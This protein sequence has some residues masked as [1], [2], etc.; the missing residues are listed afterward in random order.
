MAQGERLTRQELSWLLSQ[1]A[2]RAAQTL[3]KGVA[4]LTLEPPSA[5]SAQLE[6]SLSA[7]DDAMKMLASLQSSSV[8]RGI[9]G[10]I[11]L[12]ALVCEVTPEA[13]V[14]IAPGSG[15]EVHGDEAEL[16]RMIQVLLAQ[17]TGLEA[18][19]GAPEVWINREGD[20]V[21]VSVALGPDIVTGMTSERAWL[22]RMATRYGGRLT[23]EGGQ[24]SLLLPA[25][26]AVER[27]EME[28]LRKELDAA[29][30]QGEAYARELAAV[31]AAAEGSDQPPAATSTMPPPASSLSAVLA[32]SA[33]IA[34]Q[35]KTISASLS[36]D[37][38]VVMQRSTDASRSADAVRSANVQLQELAGELGRLSRVPLDE[39]PTRADLASMAR[40]VLEDADARA[41]RHQISLHSRVPDK[42]H[43]LVP[44]EAMQAMMRL[45]IDHAIAASPRG[46]SIWL[47]LEQQRHLVRIAVDDAG[48]PVPSGAREGLV[49]RR[50]D[51][52]TLGRPRG[53]NL[54]GAATLAAHMGGTLEIE[55][56][57]AGGVRVRATIPSR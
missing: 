6:S 11:D 41:S 19:H 44:A 43:A 36:R 50:L 49:W 7:L 57:P 8:Q 14:H 3:R 21:R 47:S 22:S 38:D 42:L 35:L 32:M 27:T 55:D 30:Q 5:P 46:A 2:R 13:R 52:A 51:P 33:E 23:L 53:V 45:V 54:L 12:A 40:Q 28:A 39:L 37:D 56:A 18:A 17:S 24:E 31:F 1:E 25:E 15:T 20:E 9:R 4:A 10:T 34:A 26:G 29:Q 16:R 48:V